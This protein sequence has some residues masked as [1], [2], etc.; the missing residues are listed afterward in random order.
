MTKKLTLRAAAIYD[1]SRW[2][3]KYASATNVTHPLG[4]NPEVKTSQALAELATIIF[5]YALVYVDNLE[6]STDQIYLF[7]TQ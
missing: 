3:L 4:K 2:S 1:V 6:A 5:S 7:S